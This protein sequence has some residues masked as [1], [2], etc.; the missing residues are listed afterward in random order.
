MGTFEVGLNAFLHYDMTK[1]LWGQ[2][3]ECGG[4]LQSIWHYKE[5]WLCWSK[6]TTLG[7]TLRSPM[8]KLL[9]MSQFTS[10]YQH[11]VELSATSVVQCLPACNRVPS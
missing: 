3:V 2:G 7:W 8:L 5:V 9:P 6:Y 10:N 1:R 11:D 4:R